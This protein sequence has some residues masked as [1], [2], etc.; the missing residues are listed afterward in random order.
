MTAATTAST[1][2]IT[3]KSPLF[4]LTPPPAIPSSVSSRNMAAGDSSRLQEAQ[5]LAKTDPR[6]AEAVYKSITSKAPQ[7]TSDAATREYES[8]LI[9]L[10]ELYRDERSASSTARTEPRHRPS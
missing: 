2:T 3:A 8:A 10:G 5:K 9:S 1:T 7:A 4:Y 6:K